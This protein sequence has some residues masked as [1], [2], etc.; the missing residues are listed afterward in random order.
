MGTISTKIIG[1]D[2]VK[3]IISI[4]NNC[5][6]KELS[7]DDAKEIILESFS[8][9]IS[10]ED[11]KPLVFIAL[12]KIQ[13]D[14]GVLDDDVLHQVIYDFKA[15]NGLTRWRE[16]SEKL[17]ELRVSEL[18][19]FID[20]LKALNEK[21][22]KRPRIIVRKPLFEKGDCLAVKLDDGNYS[23]WLVLDNDHTDL[24]NGLSLLIMMDYYD[25]QI[26][27][28]KD[29][30]EPK[31]VLK[32]Q[33]DKIISSVVYEKDG[34]SDHK[35]HLYWIQRTGYSKVKDKFKIIGNIDLMYHEPLVS[36]SYGLI[37]TIV[38]FSNKLLGK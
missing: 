32:K 2:L 6:K 23:A 7:F 21:P 35:Y 28:L 38:S 26:P 29:F 20:K 24:E 37:Q 25:S 12:A 17:Y 11:E 16:E 33:K 27:E 18:E 19:K 4:Y 8:D 14:Y 10:D 34:R 15:K 22:K 5:L 9:S 1:D 3:D 13:W 36:K 30:V 31:Y